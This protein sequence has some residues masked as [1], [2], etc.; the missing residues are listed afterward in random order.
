MQL[1]T[2]AFPLSKQIK[3]LSEKWVLFDISKNQPYLISEYQY[4]NYFVFAPFRII[5]IFIHLFIIFHLLICLLNG[6]QKDGTALKKSKYVVF[7]GP[8]FSVFC[9]N[10]GIYGPGKSPYLDTFYVVQLTLISILVNGQGHFLVK[11]IAM[12]NNVFETINS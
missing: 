12:K 9:S 2:L 7:S 11:Q 5:L 8:Y 6:R 3:I 4:Q 10:T 1:Q